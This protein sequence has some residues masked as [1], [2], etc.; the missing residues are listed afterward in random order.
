M[1]VEVMPRH[2]DITPGVPLDVT[3]SVTNTATVIGGYT[4]R[5]LGADPGW[6]RLD[7]DQ[8]S[9]FPDESRTIRATIT[10]PRG[11]PAGSRRIALQVRELTPPQDSAIHEIDLAVPTAAA[12]QI[13]VDPLAVTASRHANFGLLIENTGNTVVSGYLDGDDPEGKVSFGFTPDGIT[14]A[15]GEHALVDMRASARA[16]LAG[17]PVVRM[18]AVYLDAPSPNGFF[19]ETPQRRA[20]RDERAALANATFVQKAVLTRGPLALLGLLAAVTV[21]AVVLTVALSR[22]VGQTN[23]DR[24]LALQVAAAQNAGA[25]GGTSSISGV[26]RQ[27]TDGTPQPNVTVSVFDVV[28]VDNPLVTTATDDAGSYRIS[29]LAAGKYKVS[30]GG[31]G[32]VEL[33]YPSATDS[34][35]ASTI[36]LGPKTPTRQLNVTLGGVPATISG[37][38]TG[39]DV[40]AATLYLERLPLS[41]D[42]PP[43]G[44]SASVPSGAVPPPDNGDAVVQS[45]PIG[46]DGAFTLGDVPS[47]ATYDLVVTK[48]SYATTT[49]R[50][51]VGAGETRTGVQLTLSRGDG[52][53]SG[54]VNS[55]SGPLSQV[56]I[57]A[58]AGQTST[59]TISLTGTGAF[60][61]RNL[62]TPVSFTVVA[63]KHGFAAQ[64]QTLSLTSGEKLTGVQITLTKSSGSLQGT[65]FLVSTHQPIADV[66]VTVTGGATT[67]Q[68]GTQSLASGSGA[69]RSGVG[70][71]KVDGLP[72]PGTY[73]V[74]FT[75]ADL[76]TQ[77]VGIS[78]DSAGKVTQS[79][80]GITVDQS[81]NILV[82]MPS[83]TATITGTVK[84]RAVTGGPP[85]PVGEVTVTVASGTSSYTVITA[86]VPTDRR[87]EYTIA[88]IPPGTWTVSVS[89]AGT[90]PTSEIV[91]LHAGQ[92]VSYSPLLSVPASIGGTVKASDGTPRRGWVVQLY[93]ADQYPDVVAYSTSTDS[94]GNFSFPDVNAPQVYVVVARPSAGS[95]QVVSKTVQLDP[96]DHAN[97]TLKGDPGG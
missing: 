52:L 45:V 35:G 63:R 9:L 25:G 54:T 50:I 39:D 78:L 56:R 83:A 79:S 43:T 88:A 92:R 37:T 55:G 4:V 58:T 40:S 10:T 74:I 46:S 89:R 1:R 17:S 48:A 65:V 91:G 96:S 21:F 64:T 14:L 8:L 23:A 82:Y 27:L 31:A 5:V 2:A 12:T 22:L 13:R 11:L 76:E 47:P 95:A 26:V 6:V 81:G 62:P 77:T 20:G 18:L 57:T 94:Q 44:I 61:L 59:T 70:D 16:R 36:T 75:R 85:K 66:A 15:P 7:A 97:V 34:A 49:Q 33:W 71:W 73:T 28:D 90:T 80:K 19:D 53:I 41:D 24:D 87:G 93:E 60:T 67:V 84:Q 72:V 86:S 30:Y 42:S 38:V 68:T 32:F 51:D 3:I 69:T 29:N